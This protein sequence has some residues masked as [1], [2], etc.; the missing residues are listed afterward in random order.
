MRAVNHAAAR[1]RARHACRH[2]GEICEERE[3]PAATHRPGHLNDSTIGT[4]LAVSDEVEE[5]SNFPRPNRKEASIET[6]AGSMIFRLQII[7]I[8]MARSKS[9]DRQ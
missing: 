3:V 2:P 5:W 1:R 8:E 7:P 6:E 9:F 4:S